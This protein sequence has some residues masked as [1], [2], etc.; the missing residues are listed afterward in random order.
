MDK[1]KILESSLLEKYALGI[2]SDLEIEVVE[3]AIDLFPEVG[4]ELA[5]VERALEKAA[6]DNQ[7]QAPEGTKEAILHSIDSI[8]SENALLAQPTSSAKTE[9]YGIWSLAASFLIGGALAGMIGWSIIN[10][11]KEQLIN[12]EERTAFIEE[13]CSKDKTFF[14]FINDA[15][16]VPV[17][18]TGTS[19]SEAYSAVSY[20]NDDKRQGLLK[21]TNLPPLNDGK[22]YQIWADIDGAMLDL[23]VIDYDASIQEFVSIKH[24]PN[25]ESLNITIEP[26]GGSDHPTVST[27]IV[28]GTI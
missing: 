14:A 12:M 2:A 4:Q 16:T 18:L 9:G 11:Q 1:S 15:A 17:Y 26:A 28:S 24:I 25:A 21:V 3:Q 10:N 23:G 7:I 5:R 19:A 13:E 8:A 27:L 6:M 20:W 22:T